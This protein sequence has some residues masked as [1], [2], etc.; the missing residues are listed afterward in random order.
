M[1]TVSRLFGYAFLSCILLSF[2]S[3]ADVATDETIIITGCGVLDQPE[4]SYLLIQDIVSTDTNN[5]AC[6]TITAPH[7]TLDCGSSLIA[8]ESFG[9]TAI[10][11]NQV[12]T[13]ITSCRISMPLE[14]SRGIHIESTHEAHLSDN[15]FFN[16][17]FPFL[18]ER[19]TRVHIEDTHFYNNSRGI[20][21]IESTNNTIFRSSFEDQIYA[22]LLRES[23]NNTIAAIEVDGCTSPAGCMI[24]QFSSDNVIRRG[25]IRGTAPAVYIDSE[26]SS[27]NQ[28]QDLTFRGYEGSGIRIR[29]IGNEDNRFVNV[30]YGRGDEEVTEGNE[31]IRMWHASFNATDSD[32]NALS[33]TTVTLTDHTL[34]R[35][36]LAESTF[37]RSFIVA[38]Y[39]VN[40]TEQTFVNYSLSLD[41]TGFDSFTENNVRFNTNA[42]RSEVL[43]P[44]APEEQEED[45]G[46][47]CRS[48]WICNEWSTCTDGVQ[49][50]SCGLRLSYCLP[51]NPIEPP[52]S[53]ACIDSPEPQV[54]ELNTSPTTTG[55]FSRI[56]GAAIGVGQ[57]IIS[58][59]WVILFLAGLIAATVLV[60]F[61]RR[62]MQMRN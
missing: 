50:R 20:V 14:S 37:N 40:G 31:L 62:R 54:V 51:S 55:F 13:T 48:E 43:N 42:E 58:S 29:G 33:D 18:I 28:F 26:D 6:I 61:N 19:V 39:L 59:F 3:A 36:S 45:N 27:R 8:P 4:G 17:P 24:L 25:F 52:E 32:N 60:G 10:Y 16:S 7:V 44:T 9:G 12:N 2:A 46:G 41:H 34:G 15:E 22:L 57:A 38:Q 5:S 11:S 47:R 30:T 23:H 35:F 1:I 21:L 53:Q 56:T 49:T